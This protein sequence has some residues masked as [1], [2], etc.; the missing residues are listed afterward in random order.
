MKIF[1]AD[2]KY[3]EKLGQIL[4]QIITSYLKEFFPIFLQGDLGTGK[5]TL[6][7]GLVRALPYGENSEISSP[8]FNIVNIYPTIP[9]VVHI[10]FYRLSDTGPDEGVLEYFSDSSQ[11]V[12]TEW[13]EYFPQVYWPKEYIYISL[14]MQDKGRTAY[15]YAQGKTPEFVVIKFQKS[16]T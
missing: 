2:E 11:I 16:L 10:D 7:R 15:L 5:T 3:T 6:V 1:L 12:I 8:S 9:Q 14:S 4:A 13:S